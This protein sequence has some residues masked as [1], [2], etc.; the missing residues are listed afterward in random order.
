MPFKPLEIIRSKSREEWEAL[1]RERW[2]NAR[3][4]TQENGELALVFG[5]LA[6]IFFVLALKLVV[7][8]LVIAGL[9]AFGVWLYALPDGQKRGPSSDENPS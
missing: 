2:T 3:I 9:A 1:A 6:G 7:M 5:L 8:L 4:W